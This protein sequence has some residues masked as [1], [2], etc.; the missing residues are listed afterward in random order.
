LVTVTVVVGVGETSIFTV[1]STSH[2]PLLFKIYTSC[3]SS[4]VN[5][6]P[7]ESSCEV[8]PEAIKLEGVTDE[9]YISTVSIS[10]PI[11]KP[12]NV[13][14]LVDIIFFIINSYYFYIEQIPNCTDCP[15]P[16]SSVNVPILRHIVADSPGF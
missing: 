8:T 16:L 5:V 10:L 7:V 9:K 4:S 15:G 3:V 12:V 2:G 14:D 6:Y 11:S 13:I 1:T